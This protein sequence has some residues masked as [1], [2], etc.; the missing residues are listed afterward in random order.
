MG[1]RVVEGVTQAETLAAFVDA[2]NAWLSAR[3]NSGPQDGPRLARVAEVWTNVKDHRR[4]SVS[5]PSGS[6]H[7]VRVL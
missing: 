1:D 2:V 6:P 5:L 3:L 7:V 4:T